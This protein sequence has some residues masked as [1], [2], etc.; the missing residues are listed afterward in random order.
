MNDLKAFLDGELDAAAAGT[1][2]SRIQS[3]G[4]LAAAAADFR[5]LSS[6]LGALSVG[7]RVTGREKVMEAI[8]TPRVFVFPWKFAAACASAVLL[9][10]FVA[11]LQK[12]GFVATGVESEVAAPLA[13]KVGATG[14]AEMPAPAEQAPRSDAGA[15]FKSEE[16]VARNGSDNAEPMP[17]TVAPEDFQRKVIRT[18]ALAVRVDSVEEAETKV[19]DYVDSLRGYIENA[20]SQNLN[21][22]TPSMTMVVRIPQSKY[23]EAMATFEKLGTRLSKDSQA[24]DVTQ[25]VVDLD[26]R[27]KNLRTQEE[28]YR[29]I[30]RSANK[31]GEIVDV[32]ER[33]SAIRGEIESMQA[34]RDALSKLAALATI[35][36]RLQQRPPVEDAVS[37]G[38]IEDAW[39]SATTALGGALRSLSVMGIWIL[40]Y[41]PIWIPLAIVSVWG[42]RRALRA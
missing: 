19:T 14:G 27:L 11:N 2:Q 26:A 31:V 1:M 13:E 5:L 35:N 18:G 25:Q 12:R 7:P 28:T 16:E 42:W 30:L 20:S 40:V 17:S 38:W 15:G 3:D 32:Q 34:Q 10:A 22:T 8:R 33:I 23:S 24:S 4:S 37:S 41:A 21:G 29:A 9:V 6:S 39:N 36:L